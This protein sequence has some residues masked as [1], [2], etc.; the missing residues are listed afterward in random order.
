MGTLISMPIIEPELNCMNIEN[1]SGST[2]LPTVL[3]S[4][5]A[6]IDTD[7]R[8]L[9]AQRPAGKEMS[10]LWEFPGGKVELGETPENTLIRELDEELGIDVSASCLA[11]FTFASH[12]YENFHLLM[13]LF[14]CRQ[15][16]GIPEGKEGQKLK[17]AHLKN[18][19]KFEM[20]PADIPLVAMLKDF[21]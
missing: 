4:S 13:P 19:N 15:W 8:I 2:S 5:V 21:L 3:V 6:L 10:G 14:L 17:W 11:P 7:G 12:K 20:P 16:N 1:N 18:F 9:L